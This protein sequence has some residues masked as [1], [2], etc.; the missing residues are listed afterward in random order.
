MT[1]KV[2][3][4]CMYSKLNGGSSNLMLSPCN[5][6]AFHCLG[7]PRTVISLKQSLDYL[8]HF[9]CFLFLL[10]SVDREQFCPVYNEILDD[11]QYAAFV[12]RQFA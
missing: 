8:G 5:L 7:D 9:A 12:N 1:I 3:D 6:F 11:V 2:K 4:L 10:E